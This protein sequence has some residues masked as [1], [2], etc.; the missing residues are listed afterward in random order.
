MEVIIKKIIGHGRVATPTEEADVSFE[1]YICGRVNLGIRFDRMA[2]KADRLAI[3]LPHR[4]VALQHK[5]GID[6]GIALQQMAFKTHRPPV[7]RIRTSPQE[8]RT[9]CVVRTAVDFMASETSYHAIV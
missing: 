4:T 8:F 3:H 6:R 5:M 7:I 2:H 9:S 1:L